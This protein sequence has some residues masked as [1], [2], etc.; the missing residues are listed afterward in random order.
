LQD[1]C[2]PFL[3]EEVADTISRK[4]EIYSY[5]YS[6]LLLLLLGRSFLFVNDPCVVRQGLG[7]RIGAGI[8]V[9]YSGTTGSIDLPGALEQPLAELVAVVDMLHFVGDGA[10]KNV[11]DHVA[12]PFCVGNSQAT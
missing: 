7:R 9:G 6:Y 5:S 2:Q 4:E 12:A 10:G 1:L 8:H 11:Y 3:T